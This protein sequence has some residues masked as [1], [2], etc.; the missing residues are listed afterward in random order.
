MRCVL[1]VYSDLDRLHNQRFADILSPDTRM[2]LPQF[3]AYGQSNPLAIVS[4]RIGGRGS[5]GGS[6]GRGSVGVAGGGGGKPVLPSQRSFI[7]FT[8]DFMCSSRAN[9]VF[10]RVIDLALARRWICRAT[11][12]RVSF[13]RDFVFS[14][15]S[16]P[17]GEKRPCS[18]MEFGVSA[19][20]ASSPRQLVSLQTDSHTR[21][22]LT[23][24][25]SR[26][27]SPTL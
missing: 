7:D 17:S 1:A 11:S 15:A 21:A 26:R 13:A 22:H 16:E 8:Q 3:A 25:R 6:G 24:A 4:D 9:P 2:L 27:I 5:G 14:D 19:Q 20:H 12:G 23:P 10:K 18:T